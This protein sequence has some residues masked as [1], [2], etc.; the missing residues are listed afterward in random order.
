MEGRRG[1]NFDSVSFLTCIKICVEKY[2]E[3]GKIDGGLIQVA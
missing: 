3:K 2:L 1:N